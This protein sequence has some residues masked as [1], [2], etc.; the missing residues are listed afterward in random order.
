MPTILQINVSVNWGAHGKIAED[1]GRMATSLGWNS[2]IAY[3][4]QSNPSENHVVKIGTDAS[5][6]EHVVESRIFDNHGLASRLATKRF[7]KQI[8]EL[9]PDIIHLH[10]IH[11]YYLNYKYLFDYLAPRDIPVVWTL[12]DCWPFTGHCAYYDYAQCNKWVAQCYGPCPCKGEYPQSLLFDASNRNYLLKKRLFNSV[13]NL[14]LVPV[15]DWLGEEVKKSFLGNHP[16]QVIHNGIDLNVFKPHNS[17]EVRQRY[18]IDGSK[19]VLGVASDWEKRKGLDDFIKLPDR[20]TNDIKVVI[21]GVNKEQMRIVQSKGCIG[22]PR[23][24]NVSELAAL[25]SGAELFLNLTYEDNYP[26]TNLE[27]IACGT[28]V[29]TYKTGGSP[30]SV[31][32]NTGWVVE[33]GDMDSVVNIIGSEKRMFSGARLQCRQRAEMMFDKEKCFAAY[34]HLYERIL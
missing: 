32:S 20:L 10:N 29:L 14:T 2:V 19:Y 22:I 18:G 1:I 24:N 28:P 16:I 34:M 3:G 15:S 21:V 13:N 9:K 27:A 4:R 17:D 11:G 5:I 26:T 7:I 25:Y 30:E 33:K 12:H 31:D 6:K 8:D 23:T